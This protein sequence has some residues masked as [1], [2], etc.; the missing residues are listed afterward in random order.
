M[1][2][3]GRGV[4]HKSE[5]RYTHLKMNEIRSK[6]LQRSSTANWFYLIDFG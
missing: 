1:L 3:H 2:R 5:K 4:D 6:K